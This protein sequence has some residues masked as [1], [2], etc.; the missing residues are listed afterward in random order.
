[1]TLIII[2]YFLN[3]NFRYEKDYILPFIDNL[4]R[5]ILFFAA[6]ISSHTVDMFQFVWLQSAQKK[7][8][9]VE[10]LHGCL[11]LCIGNNLQI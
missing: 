2:W 10:L 5:A 4:L 9:P 7:R 11:Y 8:R 3:E 1:M 6:S